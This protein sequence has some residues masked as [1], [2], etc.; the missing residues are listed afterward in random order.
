MECA[1]A[2]TLNPTPD[3]GRAWNWSIA[4]WASCDRCVSL[5]AVLTAV[6]TSPEIRI[7]SRI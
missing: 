3:S 4:K 2:I 5:P 1:S 7:C 6:P